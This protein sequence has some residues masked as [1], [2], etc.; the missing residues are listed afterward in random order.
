MAP[1]RPKSIVFAPLAPQR[2]SLRRFGGK[3]RRRTQ[4][5]PSP[6]SSAW[7]GEMA[8]KTPRASR[9][10]DVGKWR[11]RK[12]LGNGVIVFSALASVKRLANGQCL[13]QSKAAG[14]M[15]RRRVVS[16]PNRWPRGVVMVRHHRLWPSY[17]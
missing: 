11:G 3:K 7:G 6:L 4:A 15:A 14:V 17:I 13:R 2:S 1:R 16:T 8:G 12:R 9:V 5:K 10:S